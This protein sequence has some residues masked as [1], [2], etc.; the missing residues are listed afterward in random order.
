MS[1]FALALHEAGHTVAALLHGVQVRQIVCRPGEGAVHLADPQAELR[2]PGSLH[3]LALVAAAGPAVDRH[4]DAQAWKEYPRTAT[5]LEKLALLSR[6]SGLR[7][8]AFT[9]DEILDE[10][11]L[12]VA[13]H[14]PLIREAASYLAR[15]E[16][17]EGVLLAQLAPRFGAGWTEAP[18]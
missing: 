5:D 1:V 16:V 2:R 3:R 14:M 8:R 17:L 4:H 10:A 18:R 9:P 13:N 11:G 6:A 12:L 15:F 7:G